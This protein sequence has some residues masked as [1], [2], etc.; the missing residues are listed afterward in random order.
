MYLL[1]TSA[2]TS[3]SPQLLIYFRSSIPV[4]RFSLLSPSFRLKKLCETGWVILPS[5]WAIL[6]KIFPFDVLA[7]WSA[8]C[9]NSSF[10]PTTYWISSCSAR[11]ATAFSTI[12]RVEPVLQVTSTSSTCVAPLQKESIAEVSYPAG[13]VPRHVPFCMMRS[14]SFTPGWI[15]YNTLIACLQMFPRFAQGQLHWTY[16]SPGINIV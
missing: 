2:K 5:D 14:V 8:C 9:S 6:S 7:W 3:S 16:S 15:I 13:A 11:K 4:L 10:S 1:I 12:L